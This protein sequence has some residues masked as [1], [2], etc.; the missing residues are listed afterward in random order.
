MGPLAEA[1]PANAKNRGAANMRRRRRDEGRE[2]G[3]N[4]EGSRAR[5]GQEVREEQGSREENEASE[6]EELRRVMSEAIGEMER[7]EEDT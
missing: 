2:T 3:R 6:T 7:K 5:E 4:E 1:T